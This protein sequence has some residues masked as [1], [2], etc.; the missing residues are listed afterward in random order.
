MRTRPAG[1]SAATSTSAP[2]SAMVWQSGSSAGVCFAAM[3]PEMRAAASASPFSS[4][5]SLRSFSA[6]LLQRSSA[7]ATA[8]RE[9]R[10]FSPTSIIFTSATS[11]RGVFSQTAIAQLIVV[12]AVEVPHL[13]QQGIAD[14][15]VQLLVGMRGPCEVAT[16]E[17]DGGL[18]RG[19]SA[20][21]RRAEEP[22]D[23]GRERR[24]GRRQVALVGQVDD[25]ELALREA[26]LDFLG[27]LRHLFLHH[28]CE[29]RDGGRRRRP[30]GF[31]V[32][33][34]RAGE[35]LRGR[36]VVVGALGDEAEVMLCPGVGLVGGELCQLHL[37]LAETAQLEERDALLPAGLAVVHV[38]VERA[39]GGDERVG[40][41]P[42]I[43]VRHRLEQVQILEERA[44]LQ[45]LRAYQPA[46]H[47]GE[48]ELE[49]VASPEPADVQVGRGAQ[50]FGIVR[51]EDQGARVSGPRLVQVPELGE[52]GAAEV[53]GGDALRVEAGGF[54]G[55][56]Q[57]ALEAALL[58]L[59]G[60][61][62]EQIGNRGV[63]ATR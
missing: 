41:P 51:V 35:V 13:V 36:D 42:E 11:P 28:L 57:R 23:A 17:E 55:A 3:M 20:V 37:G 2:A 58:E 29:R 53:M 43:V 21:G 9:V 31:R 46:L 5:P 40:G 39:V 56:F 49:I 50:D 14:F 27:K 47:V 48:G 16:V 12:L 15:A 26:L 19:R 7:R 1:S 54:P 33:L 32:E 38:V 6:S 4:R 8:M 62:L 24:I 30:E 22:E 63:L 52:G 10:S 60:G 61:L 18:V 44:V 59:A 45:L 34:L 25:R